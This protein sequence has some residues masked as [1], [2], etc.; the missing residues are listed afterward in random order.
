MCARVCVRIVK[1]DVC[2]WSFLISYGHPDGDPNSCVDSFRDLSARLGV[3]IE[4]TMG[5]PM[6]VPT[7]AVD[8]PE[9]MAREIPVVI[10]IPMQMHIHGD[11]ISA[12][13][14]RGRLGH[15]AAQG[16]GRAL[17]PASARGDPADLQPIPMEMSMDI[18]TVD[19][20][21]IPCGLW[22]SPMDTP[23]EIC[24]EVPLRVGIPMEV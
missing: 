13:M 1:G 24:A 4:I 12:E 2:L 10:P 23:V 22:I 3:H 9:E 15:G 5:N 11:S 21:G 18:P 20:V 14:R 16:A 17:A 19:P 8:F 6:G 7:W